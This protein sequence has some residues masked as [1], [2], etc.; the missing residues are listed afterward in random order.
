MKKIRLKLIISLI[1]LFLISFRFLNRVLAEDES[2]YFE[3]NTSYSKNNNGLNSNID[4]VSGAF[5]YSYLINIP[6]GR[7]GLEPNLDIS[8]NNQLSDEASLFGY[9]WFLNI[10]CITRYLKEGINN[11]YTTNYFNSSLSGELVEINL[12]DGTHGIYGSKIENGSFLKY[13]YLNDNTWLIIDKQGTRYKFGTTNLSRQDD[14]NDNTK[15][16]KW[17]L[18]EVRDVN[19][20]FIRYEYFKD[21]GQIYPDK[22]FYTGHDTIDGI[23]EVE[24]IRESRDDSDTAYNTQFAVETEYRIK[25]VRIYNDDEIYKRYDLGYGTGDNG[26]RS[27]LNSITEVGFDEQGNEVELPIDEFEYFSEI[28]AWEEDE[29]IEIPTVFNYRSK[30]VGDVNGDGYVDIVYFTRTYIG[31][32]TYLNKGDGTGWEE[33]SNFAP[34]PTFASNH[35]IDSI[36]YDLAD[37]NGDRYLDIIYTTYIQFFEDQPVREIYI[38]RGDGTGWENDSNYVF[39]VNFNAFGPGYDLGNRLA[40]INGDGLVDVVG[41]IVYL[42]EGDGAGWQT[43]STYV[44]PVSFVRDYIWGQDDNHSYQDAGLRLVDVNGDNLPDLVHY[45][46]NDPSGIYINNG[47][48]WVYDEDYTIP[49]N[50]VYG[51]RPTLSNGVWF[52][53]INNDNLVDLVNANDDDPIVVYLNKSDGT[54]WEISV[55]YTLPYRF[56][57]HGDDEDGGVRLGDF[58][59]DGNL[60]FLRSWFFDQG[61]GIYLVY[62]NVNIN[63]ENHNDLLKVINH[64]YGAVT[65]INY[66]GIGEYKDS[67]DNLLNPNSMVNLKT[68]ESVEIN[69]GMGNITEIGYKYYGADNYYEDPYTS[70]FAGFSKVEKYFDDGKEITYFFQGNDDNTELGEENDSYYKKSRVY[71]TEL[72]QENN[73]EYEKVHQEISKLQEY[74][75]GNESKFVFEEEQVITD[76]ST[77]GAKSRAQIN[78]YDLTNG[79]LLAEESY[80][81]V[82][83]LNDGSFTDIVGD[84]KGKFYYYAT[85]LDPDSNMISFIKKIRVI[86]LSD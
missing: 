29:S 47:Q 82:N 85:P 76:F 33:N 40:D 46:T 70:E 1:I 65:T 77:S 30:Q 7:N 58:M 79:N 86:D 31:G 80:G 52:F 8:Y 42:N 22:I 20:N 15:I 69:D 63:M 56:N 24:F 27:I 50:I 45:N 32:Q 84:E 37:V 83:A 64:R 28:P 12:F 55:G 51:S 10:P 2:N 17:M 34:P 44:L 18:E 62:N 61:G 72:W 60:D 13:E 73:G 6:P 39:P 11:L 54:G 36:S 53:D 49:V 14:P 48:T 75:L 21:N 19:D 71:R 41:D 5:T 59:G 68:V 67:L 78:T 26:V 23:F 43:S 38:N 81:E 3:S 4:L 57:H 16:Y 66:K 74:D 9:G 25:E 35:I